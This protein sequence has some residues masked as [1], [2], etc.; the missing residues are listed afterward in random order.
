[1]KKLTK[2]ILILITI[3]IVSTVAGGLLFVSSDD[4]SEYTSGNLKIIELNDTKTHNLNEIN[5][6]NI[7]SVSTD[8]E[9]IKTNNSEASFELI[10]YYPKKLYSGPLTLRFEEIKG[11]INVQI[12]YPLTKLTLGMAQHQIDLKV[13]LPEDYLGDLEL[14]TISGEVFVNDFVLE[15]IQ[16]KAVSGDIFLKRVNSGDLKIKTVSGD[17]SLIETNVNEIQTT[18][19]DIFLE[20]ILIDR[21]LYIHTIS[22]DTEIKYAN[23]SSFFVE[24]NSISGDLEKDFE[25]KIGKGDYKV[26]VKTTSGDFEIS[27]H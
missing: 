24:Y 11:V 16:I 23:N 12:I 8:I 25:H 6:I 22:G 26:L 5:L 10:G 7:D 27:K 17:L 21:N 3:F 9:L 2:T 20:E 15:K 1:M 13:Y 4:F 19:G 18:S 14:S